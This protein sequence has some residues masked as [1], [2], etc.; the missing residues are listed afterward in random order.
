ML[1]GAIITAFII[2]V[3]VRVCKWYNVKKYQKHVDEIFY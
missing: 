2:Y 3:G 1:Q